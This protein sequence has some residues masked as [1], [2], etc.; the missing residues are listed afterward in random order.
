MG[1]RDHHSAPRPVRGQHEGQL[2]NR[3][4]IEPDGRFIKKPEGSVG[5]RKP[6]ERRRRFCPADSIRAGKSASA[7]R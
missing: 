6:T 4:R 7:P 5:Q 2:L 3:K 1:G